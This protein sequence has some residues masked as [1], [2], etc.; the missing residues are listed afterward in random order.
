PNSVCTGLK[1]EVRFTVDTAGNVLLPMDWRGILVNQDA[2]PVPRLLRGSTALEALAGTGLPVH[3]PGPAF[4]ASF[5]PDGRK[6]PP[7]FAPQAD[8]TDPTAAA[9]FGSAD[10]PS[11]VLRV[12]RRAPA[13]RCFGG[14]R[15]DTPCGAPT[16]CPGGTCVPRF[17]AC[18]TGSPR[19]ELPC[20][21]DADCGGGAGSCGVAVCSGGGQPG[22]RCRDDADCPGGEC[23]LAVF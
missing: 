10:A 14:T 16:D 1:Q 23:G 4:L 2:V 8:P 19:P 15:A 21:G 9:L 11:T 22:Q 12:A 5:S 6:L 18:A 7:I 17:L 13:L 3:V 20:T